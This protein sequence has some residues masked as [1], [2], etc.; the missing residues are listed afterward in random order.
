MGFQFIARYSKQLSE[1]PI[2]AITTDNLIPLLHILWDIKCYVWVSLLNTMFL[3]KWKNPTSIFKSTNIIYRTDAKTQTLH[4]FR[5]P[6]TLLA[7]A[8]Q[9]YEREPN[10]AL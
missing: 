10:K 9:P 2:V 1:L 7:V 4:L 5:N 6:E 3:K 8:M